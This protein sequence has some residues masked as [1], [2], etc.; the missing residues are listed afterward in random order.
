[1]IAKQSM[2][3]A[4]ELRRAR[5]I[6]G[7]SQREAAEDMGVPPQTYITWEHGRRRPKAVLYVKAARK[8][9]QRASQA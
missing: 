1:M 2:D 6:R 4:T 3:W 7:H 5:D 8:Y 9:I